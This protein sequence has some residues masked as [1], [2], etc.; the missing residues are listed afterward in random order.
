MTF[1]VLEDPSDGIEAGAGGSGICLESIEEHTALRR[2][3]DREAGAEGSI[4]GANI[5]DSPDGSE[6]GAGGSGI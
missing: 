3:V 1:V 6:A 4:V 5:G 2:G